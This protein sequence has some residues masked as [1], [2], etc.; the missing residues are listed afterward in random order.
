M[1]PPDDERRTNGPRNLNGPRQ[2]NGAEN[3]RVPQR[4]VSSS[5]P[6]D[7]RT[8]PAATHLGEI[9]ARLERGSGLLV[10]VDFDGTLAPIVDDPEEPNITPANAV[11]LARLT[12]RPDTVVA[13]VSGREIGD[14]RSRAE[15][16]GAVYAGNH[17][18]E[19][20]R[21]HE[22]VVHPAA[23]RHRPALDHAA[24]LARRALGDVP[25][26]L[27]EDKTLSLTVHYRQ[28]PPALQRGVV[29]RLDALAP[30]LDD[31]LCLVSG[32]KSVEIRPDI[33]WDKGQAVQWIRTT[34]PDG[35]RAVYLGDDTTDEDVFRSLDA[36]DVGVHVGTRDTVARYRLRYQRDVAPFLDWLGRRVTTGV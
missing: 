22:M 36:G 3:E 25:G 31:G 21:D 2:P 7:G 19:L 26:C 9:A 34:L 1:Y 29:D 15:V 6:I 30:E 27:I 12:A 20:A 16:P 33:D 18:L 23:R 14:L 24:T 28:V 8:K 32:R 10:G 4:V 13:V 35:Y 5:P 11:A 17:G